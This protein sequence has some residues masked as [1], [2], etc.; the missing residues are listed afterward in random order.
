M[1]PKKSLWLATGA[2]LSAGL[3]LAVHLLAP[4]NP[5]TPH[6]GIVIRVLDGHTLRLQDRRIIRIAHIQAPS[7]DQPGGQAAARGLDTLLL[8]RRVVLINPKPAGPG[9]WTATVLI[10]GEQDAGLLMLKSG[11]AWHRHAMQQPTPERELYGFLEAEAKHQR[12]GL[13]RDRRPVAPWAWRGLDLSCGETVKPDV[14]VI[15][16]IAV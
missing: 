6:A 3:A 1:T 7:L 16:V 15:R 8:D 14:I 4:A 9:A 2:V 5:P 12:R 13:W 10:D 11:H